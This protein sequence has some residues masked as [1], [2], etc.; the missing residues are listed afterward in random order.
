[1]SPRDNASKNVRIPIPS[2]T[3]PITFILAGRLT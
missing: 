1:M 2:S 3:E